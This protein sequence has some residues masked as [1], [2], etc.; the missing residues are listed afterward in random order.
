MLTF[1]LSINDKKGPL[2]IKQ[3]K[4][5]NLKFKERQPLQTSNFEL[6]KRDPSV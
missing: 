2:S 6:K 4:V 3:F 5:Q 1:N